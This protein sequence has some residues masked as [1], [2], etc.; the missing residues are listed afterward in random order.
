MRNRNFWIGTP[1]LF[2][3]LIAGCSNAVEPNA[4][5]TQPTQATTATT[6]EAKKENEATTVTTSEVKK[7]NKLT[8]DEYKTLLSSVPHKITWKQDEENVIWGHPEIS[9]VQ[10]KFQG[11][12][13]D[14]T[15]AGLVLLLNQD[16]SDLVEGMKYTK[17]FL[18]SAYKTLSD[19]EI[20]VKFSEAVSGLKENGDSV[21]IKHDGKIIKY[22]ALQIQGTAGL[23]INIGIDKQGTTN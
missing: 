10:F 9:I 11:D 7:E 12:P 2:A 4:G 3:M 16:K 14:L 18:K 15:E 5:N 17:A 6:T 13:T 20:G 21:E 22:T 8:L 23:V 1:V 19:E